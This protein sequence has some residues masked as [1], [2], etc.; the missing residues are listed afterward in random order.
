MQYGLQSRDLEQ[1]IIN[2]TTR[3]TLDPGNESVRSY[4]HPASSAPTA[5]PAPCSAYRTTCLYLAR[6]L[7]AYAVD[8]TYA[9]PLDRSL[10]S[11][12]FLSEALANYGPAAHAGASTSTNGP[13]RAFIIK[14]LNIMDPLLPTN[15]LG[16]SVGKASFAR[17][18]RAFAYGAGRLE[19]IL[20]QVSCNVDCTCRVVHVRWYVYGDMFNVFR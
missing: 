17:I 16:R 14:F 13:P 19:A 20:V 3:S 5:L 7:Y 2:H 11:D 12:S 1:A 10:L 4:R 9:I 15:N 18:K 8:P 6:H